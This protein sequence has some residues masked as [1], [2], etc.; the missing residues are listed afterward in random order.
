M[1]RGTQTHRENV[2][3]RQ[4]RLESGVCEPKSVKDYRD[5]SSWER[6]GNRVPQPPEGANTADTLILG[7]W[8]PELG[9]DESLS[10]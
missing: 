7:F 4:Q 2:T 8:P 5:P 1:R 6:P 3:W 9:E 10:L